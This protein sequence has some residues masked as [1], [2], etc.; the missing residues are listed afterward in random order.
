LVRRK[1]DSEEIGGYFI[2]NGNE[3]LIRF[4]TAQRRNYVSFGR[5]YLKLYHVN[6][7]IGF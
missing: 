7:D 3:R 5:F 4:L 1:E 6:D 2:I